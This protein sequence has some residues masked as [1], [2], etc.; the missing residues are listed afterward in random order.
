MVHILDIFVSIAMSTILFL[1]GC[2]DKAVKDNEGNG[3]SDNE[4][5]E[6]VETE[7]LQLYPAPG[8]LAQNVIGMDHSVWVNDQ[9]CF[10]YRTEATGGG[11][12]GSVYPEYAYFDFKGSVAIKV[13]P[14]YSVSS[15]EILPSRAQIVPK[16]NGSEISFHIPGQQT[17]NIKESPLR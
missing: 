10:V 7:Y 17:Q 11:D 9:S 3:G 15:V 8:N 13:K 2:S 12:Y 16:V 1:A 6:P 5:D 4:G 14:N